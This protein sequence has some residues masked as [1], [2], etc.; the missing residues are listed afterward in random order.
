[1]AVKVAFLAVLWVVLWVAC[2]VRPSGSHGPHNLRTTAQHAALEHMEPLDCQ[3]AF[4]STARRTLSP[5]WPLR[6]VYR[7]PE[8]AHRYRSGGFRAERRKPQRA[9]R[10]LFYNPPARKITVSERRRSSVGGRGQS[11]QQTPEKIVGACEKTARRWA[12]TFL[13]VKG[14]SRLPF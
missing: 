8:Q 11:E 1:M 5:A 14:Y 13:G 12:H 7:R 4:R 2:A 9:R 10:A 6:P 3:P